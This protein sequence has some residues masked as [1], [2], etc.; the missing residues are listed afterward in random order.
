M[1]GGK[2]PNAIIKAACCMLIFMLVIDSVPIKQLPIK[3]E[4]QSTNLE[5]QYTHEIYFHPSFLNPKQP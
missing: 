5:F 1:I 4:H 2:E 3:S